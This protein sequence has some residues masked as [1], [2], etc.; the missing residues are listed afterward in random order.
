MTSDPER[1]AAERGR[2][3]LNDP[4]C[5]IEETMG[6]EHGSRHEVEAQ[7]TPG[8]EAAWERATD[9]YS[10]ISHNHDQGRSAR[11]DAERRIYADLDRDAGEREIDKRL[12]AERDF[13][14]G[15]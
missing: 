14:A 15:Q 13:E 3:D 10:D 4:R 11:N 6:W 1:D 8:Q 12:A 2:H 5:M 7:L 9:L